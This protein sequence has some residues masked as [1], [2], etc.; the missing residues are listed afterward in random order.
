MKRYRL[1]IT[2]LL[3]GFIFLLGCSD[4][5]LAKKDTVVDGI[6]TT[7]KFGFSTDALVK[8]VTKSQLSEETESRVEDLFVLIFHEV[9][10]NWVVEK[11]D[12][13]TDG[14]NESKGSFTWNITSGTKRIFAVANSKVSAYNALSQNLENV[15]TFEEFKNLSAEMETND[16][17]RTGALLMC[18]SYGDTDLGEVTID[19]S[20][21]ATYN[22]LKLKR[23]DSRITFSVLCNNSRAKFTPKEWYVVNIPKKSYVLGR[24]DGDIMKTSQDLAEDYSSYY[25]EKSSPKN[26]EKLSTDSKGGGSFTFYMAENMREALNPIKDYQERE[27]QKKTDTGELVPE[28]EWNYVENGAFE[29][30]E[31]EATYVVMTGTYVE[32]ASNLRAEVRYTV[33]LGYVNNVSDFHSDRNK[34]YTYTVTINGVN[35]IITEVKDGTENQPGAEG[36]VIISQDLKLVDSH[37]DIQTIT[38]DLDKVSE[39]ASFAVKTPYDKNN[40]GYDCKT[41]ELTASDYKWVQFLENKNGSTSLQAYPLQGQGLKSIKDVID[42]LY[43]RSQ[44]SENKDKSKKVVYTVFID[45]FYYDTDPKSGK[46]VSW[47]EFVNQPNREM[48]ILCNTAYS[49]DKAS[50]LTTSSFM[51]SQRSIKTFYDIENPSVSTAWGI[52]TETEGYKRVTA[53]SRSGRSDS[54]GHD[55]MIAEGVVDKDWNKYVAVST[56]KQKSE[57]AYTA[58]MQRNRDLNGNGVID[59]NEVKWYLPA[60]NQMFGYWIGKDALP[61]EV[62]IVPNGIQDYVQESNGNKLYYNANYH[63]ITSNGLTFWAEEGASTSPG[64]NNSGSDGKFDYRCVR[65]LGSVTSF[66]EYVDYKNYI[67]D[68]GK[69]SSKSLRESIV[70]SELSVEDEL[71]TNNLPHKRFQLSKDY[72]KGTLSRNDVLLQQT[73]CD[74][75]VGRKD[76]TISGA[77]A[78]RM[79]NQ[80]EMAL[81]CAYAAGSGKDVELDKG[82]YVISHTKSSLA[83]RN[84]G[85][86]YKPGSVYTLEN[87]GGSYIISLYQGEKGK[88]RCVRDIP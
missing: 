38:F 12:W 35:N 32:E 3:L 56:N 22:S 6:P 63:F 11:S 50:S 37:Y 1:H 23:V 8:V 21:N 65:N 85:S 69:L 15:E 25:Y 4:E 52:E 68:L 51:I 80:R 81:I 86:G 74:K 47:K 9:N 88:V 36:Q 2:T 42:D 67:F 60:E 53:K 77:G 41:G 49:P 62:H 24:K 84:E 27:K 55:N 34:A 20:V 33:H 18:G 10:G 26:F 14:M 44:S 59:E 17:F 71:H 87:R 40:E 76:Q 70:K 16:I 7:V 72:V 58:C 75:Y 30:V 73:L 66:D 46:T 57:D 45:E 13:V 48:H 82:N 64:V 43:K 5:D 61:S 83:T 19:S 31:A 79:P 78:W 54:N 28:K 29:N 39:N